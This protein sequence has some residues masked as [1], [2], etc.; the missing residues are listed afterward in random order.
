LVGVWGVWGWWGVPRV[1]VF[2]SFFLKK[3]G[4]IPLFFK[5]RS[6]HRFSLPPPATV[7]KKRLHGKA[8]GEAI[9]LEVRINHAPKPAA[10]PCPREHPA[11]RRRHRLRLE[12]EFISLGEM[13]Q[14]ALGRGKWASPGEDIG[15]GFVRFG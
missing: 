3:V 12:W 4:A 6:V 5:C 1:W 7:G 15:K 2:F 8:R 11:I 13:S 9:G 10:L 14:G